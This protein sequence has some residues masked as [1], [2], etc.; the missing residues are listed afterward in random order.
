MKRFVLIACGL[1]IGFSLG[2]SGTGDGVGVPAN[3]A[4]SPYLYVWAWDRE[5]GDEDFLAVVDVDPAS[6]DYGRIVETVPVGIAGG[7]HHTEYETSADGRL[8]ANSF[9]AGRTFVL[10]VTDA[11]SPRVASSFAERGPYAYP[12]S[13][14]RSPAGTVLGTFQRAAGEDDAPG[15]LVEIDRDGSYLRGSSAADPI[16]PELRPYSLAVVPELDRVVTTTAD[17]VGVH[18]GRS[19][20]V[21]RLSD[22]ALLHTVLLPPGPRGD[23]HLHPGE[24]R[25]LDDGESVLI[26]T[27][28]CGLYSL[29]DLDTRPVARLV[30]S[31]P[32]SP[33]AGEDTDCNVPV[34]SGSFWIQPVGTTGS[35]VVLDLSDLDQPV[36][37]DELS[38]GVDAR[39][40]WLAMEPGG[41]RL[42]L[43][44]GGTLEGGVFLLQFDP[45]RGTLGLI[46]GFRSP[47]SDRPG[48]RFDRTDWP[49]GA[50]GAAFA[51][52]AVFA[53]P[54]GPVAGA[55]GR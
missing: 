9:A 29:T 16:D 51:H 30:R 38:L 34:R 42:V 37:V 24:V 50:T 49:H 25:V 3:A 5:G 52:G 46:E 22:L 40:H 39:P 21:W 13:F 1:S 8:F 15:G 23:E 43:T 10:D 54:G 27:F 14:T 12:H 45:E 19:V 20:Q 17:M 53:M 36:I 28:R 4:M 35:I 2:C 48:I 41:T 44:G 33:V 55:N 18:E 11:R 32:W 31:F 47:E 6:D 7:A 26:T